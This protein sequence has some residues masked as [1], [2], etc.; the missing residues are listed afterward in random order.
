[1]S[2][3][4]AR[5]PIEVTRVGCRLIGCQTATDGGDPT[6]DELL[7]RSNG[8]TRSE[9]AVTTGLVV[10]DRSIKLGRPSHRRDPCC[11]AAR[12]DNRE[13]EAGGAVMEEGDDRRRRYAHR[14]KAWRLD[15]RC[16]SGTVLIEKRPF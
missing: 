7:A 6:V 13:W 5:T 4:W 9:V 15:N 12:E 3:T 1:M 8:A 11:S 14:T 16:A 2:S 10:A